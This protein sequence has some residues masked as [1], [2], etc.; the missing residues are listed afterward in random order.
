M[1][2]RMKNGSLTRKEVK[3]SEVNWLPTP[4][5]PHLPT[6]DPLPSHTPI[7]LS[8][9]PFPTPHIL[10]SPVPTL[11]TLFHPHNSHPLPLFWSHSSHTFPFAVV[12]S[13]LTFHIP[14]L[15]F[16]ISLPFSSSLP[17]CIPFPHR[18]SSYSLLIRP[19]LLIS[20]LLF[21]PPWYSF[22]S[23]K[24]LLMRRSKVY[25]FLQT[26]SEETIMSNI[27]F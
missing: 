24:L 12:L 22:L 18:L 5:T 9:F 23:P 20:L 19:L 7:Y 8:L 27:F 3:E 1:N 13:S 10:P 6:Y 11:L 14:S 17:L 26:V 25:W 21:C 16:L 2:K 15:F 4:T